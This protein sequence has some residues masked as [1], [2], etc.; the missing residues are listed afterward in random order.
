MSVA[1][2]LQTIQT[3]KSEI[4]TS[5]INKGVEVGDDFTTY[6]SA[7]ETIESNGPTI[8]LKD[9]T[10]TQNGIYTADEGEGYDRIEVNVP[11]TNGD[12]NEGYNAGKQNQKELLESITITDN[13]TYIREDGYNEIVVEVDGSESSYEEGYQD[14]YTQGEEDQKG[15]LSSTTITKNG[16]FTRENGWK[17][18]TVNVGAYDFTKQLGYSKADNNRLNSL[19]TS[20]VE[21]GI[22]ASKNT[23]RPW[24]YV[25]GTYS[26]DYAQC[27][28]LYYVPGEVTQRTDFE[29]C[30][31]LVRIPTVDFTGVDHFRYG[32]KN[33]HHLK[34]ISLINT[35][36]IYG[37]W[38]A[39]IGLY[40]LETIS[41]FNCGK[42]EVGLTFEN[43]YNLKNVGGF[44]DF[45]KAF[46][47]S[48]SLDLS[49]S[50]KISYQSVLNILR[51]VY[52]MTLTDIANCWIQFSSSTR[53]SEDEMGEYDESYEDVLRTEVASYFTQK[54]WSVRFY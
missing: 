2:K 17:K 32:F 16:T 28:N 18:V 11:D 48:K 30:V 8:N 27:Y 50:S 35:D 37:D 40:N 38:G 6:A 34:E 20:F 26:G 45:G 54:G 15:K 4:K 39:F 43:A 53:W 46:K 7:I 29:G 21:D 31:S 42:L 51:S 19:L 47:S 23:D 44:T 3:I 25:F 14:G 36:D 12:Y 24:E 10:I 33:C 13:G 41:E 49:H 5:I 9:I 52:N 1:D 22:A